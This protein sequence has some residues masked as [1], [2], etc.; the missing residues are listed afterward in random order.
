MALELTDDRP[1]LPPADLMLRVLPPFGNVRPVLRTR[2]G[3]ELIGSAGSRIH[4]TV[5]RNVS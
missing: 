4:C 1:P 3:A 2:Y 5:E